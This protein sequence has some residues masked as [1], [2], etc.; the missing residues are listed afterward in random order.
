MLPEVGFQGE[1]L[2]KGSVDETL[3]ALRGKIGHQQFLQVV[4]LFLNVGM[5]LLVLSDG[6]VILDIFVQHGLHIRKH[7]GFLIFKVSGELLG[8]I[9]EE[10]GDNHFVSL[11]A[12]SHKR[13][14]RLRERFYGTSL[15][16]GMGKTEV[17]QHVPQVYLLQHFTGRS[18]I[19]RKVNIAYKKKAGSRDAGPGTDIAN[20]LIS[21]AI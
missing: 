5:V 20:R 1:K 14:Q 17:L 6:K 4:Q 18:I 9:G 3:V 10:A 12:G 11:S 16:I 7:D 13:I 15:I 8:I 21:K 2:S 19:I